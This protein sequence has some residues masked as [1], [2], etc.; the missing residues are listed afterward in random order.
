M[1]MA[2]LEVLEK[3]TII[4][5]VVK[6]IKKQYKT[7]LIQ[8]KGNFYRISMDWEKSEVYGNKMYRKIGIATM[9]SKFKTSEERD[10]WF[11][12]YIKA[13]DKAADIQI[14]V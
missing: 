9:T 1:Q 10:R 11:K 7:M 5:C 13:R 6:I 4:G 8:Y 3:G 14:Y 12:A 2:T